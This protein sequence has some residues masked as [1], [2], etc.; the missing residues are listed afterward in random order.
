M[1]IPVILPR[2][3]L[4]LHAR[5]AHECLLLDDGS[6]TDIATKMKAVLD[7]PALARRL[8]VGA[9]SFAER[10]FSWDRSARDLAAFYGATLNRS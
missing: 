8:A 7:D 4:G 10:M 6:T 5:D 2:S 9:R 3:N 1:G